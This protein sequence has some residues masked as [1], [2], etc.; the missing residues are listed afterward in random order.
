MARL[1]SAVAERRRLIILMCL[2]REDLRVVVSPGP[3]GRF[4]GE[5]FGASAAPG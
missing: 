2:A 5:R 1:L 3:G 4:A